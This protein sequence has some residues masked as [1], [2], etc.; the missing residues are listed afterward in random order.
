MR[1]KLVRE[2]Y[3]FYAIEALKRDFRVSFVKP[4]REEN[5]TKREYEKRCGVERKKSLLD[6]ITIGVDDFART[7]FNKEQAFAME[8]MKPD[9]D[10]ES[11]G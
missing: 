2:A 7:M 3:R 11:E 4:E 9:S 6:R 8:V 5:E 10:K 1:E